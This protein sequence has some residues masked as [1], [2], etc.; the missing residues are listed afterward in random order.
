M[1]ISSLTIACA[2]YAGNAIINDKSSSTVQMQI[3]DLKAQVN[4]L[5]KNKHKDS[6][7]R[8]ISHGNIGNSNTSS[9]ASSSLVEID[10]AKGNIPLGLL[11]SYQYPLA[12]LK[13]RGHY[14]NNTIVLG[15]CIESNTKSFWGNYLRDG[16]SKLR[17]TFGYGTYIPTGRLYVASNIGKYMQTNLTLEA[18]NNGAK[19]S[20]KEAFVT[21]GNLS[22][23]PFYVTLG[24][25]RMYLG[26]FGGGALSINGIGQM[27][28]QPGYIPNVTLG[29]SKNN[30]MANLSF[31]NG[32][33]H[34]NLNTSYSIAYTNS[35]GEVRYSGVVGYVYN[36][37]GTGMGMLNQPKNSIANDKIIPKSDR[38]SVINFD[39][40]LTYKNYSLLGGYATTASPRPYTNNAKASAFY[41]QGIYS[42]P[43]LSR[44]TTFTFAYNRAYNT[45]NFVF[46]KLGGTRT[47]LSGVRYLYTASAQRPFFSNKVLLGL[48]YGRMT[49]YSNITFNQLTVDFSLYI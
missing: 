26:K 11:P 31:F 3:A 32:Q 20:V 15:G 12:L 36:I 7:N 2:S 27:I 8:V 42:T 44:K 13:A 21:F 45:Q 1:C 41:I 47:S 34:K 6:F 48:E 46:T 29:Y 33:S 49:T 40:Q 37:Q 25:S 5:E 30:F 19:S 16:S 17:Y 43:I 24:K 10:S 35:F 28:F 4:A 38:N 23:M 14:G 39:G 18:L 22:N 9:I